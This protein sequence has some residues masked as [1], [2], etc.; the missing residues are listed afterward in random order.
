[1]P[2][3]HYQSYHMKTSV[4][5]WK[6]NKGQPVTITRRQGTRENLSCITPYQLPGARGLGIDHAQSQTSRL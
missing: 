3:E 5:L 6:Q 4:W 2:F 1:M